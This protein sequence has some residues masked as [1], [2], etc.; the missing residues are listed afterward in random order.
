MS[1][2][3]GDRRERQAE[4]FYQ[5]AG[6]KTEICR[7]LRWGKTD[8]FGLFDVMAVHP[9]RQV[10]FAQVKSNGARGI[11]DWMAEATRIMPAEHV[12][13]DFLVCHDRE[14]WRVLRPEG[15]SYTTVLDER[16]L[17]CAMGEGVI[18]WLE[19]EA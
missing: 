18:K 19:G 5:A 3:K 12:T 15:E 10:R 16:E 2:A 14:G 8:W 6:Y 13:L 1:K 7:G 4:S 17:D 11:H 9:A